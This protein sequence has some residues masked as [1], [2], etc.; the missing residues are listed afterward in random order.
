MLGGRARILGLV[1]A[2]LGLLTP[3]SLVSGEPTRVLRAHRF[4]GRTWIPPRVLEGQ[5]GLE[6]GTP[7]DDE[8]VQ[9]ALERLLAFRFIE[10]AGPPREEAVDGGRGVD[11]IWPIRERKQVR[12]LAIT[13]KPFGRGEAFSTRELSEDL[14]TRTGQPLIALD[15]EA[16]RQAIRTRYLRAGYPLCEVGA[17]VTEPA[18]GAAEVKLTV[19]EGP[20]VW[21]RSIEIAGNREVPESHILDAMVSRR[22]ILFGLVS[23]GLYDSARFTEDVERV[24]DLYRERGFLEALVAEEPPRYTPDFHGVIAGIKIEEGPRYRLAGVSI[25]GNGKGVPAGLLLKQVHTRPGGF[26]D[27]RSLEEDRRR[28]VRWYEEHYDRVPGIDIRREVR[29]DAADSEV[30]VVFQIDESIHLQTGRVNIAGN[31]RTRD[32]VVRGALDVRPGGPLTEIALQRSGLRLV[33]SGYYEPEKLK[34]T[35][36]PG[37]AVRE[38]DVKVEERRTGM[39]EVGGGAGSGSGEIAHFSVTQTNFDLFAIPGPNRP[40][41]DAFSGGGQRLSLVFEPGTVESE[42]RL[43]FE[44]PYLYNSYQAL[45]VQAGGWQ[46]SREAYDETGVGAEVVLKRFWDQEHRFSSSLAW[47]PEDVNIS[48]LSGRAPPD[49]TAVEGHTLISYPSLRFAWNDL[50]LNYWRGPVGLFAEVRGDLAADA[51]GSEAS[52]FRT[53]MRA[54]YFQPV[55]QWINAALGKDVLGDDPRRLHVLRLGGRFGWSEGLEGDDIPFFERFYLGGPQGGAFRRSGAEG[56]RG[57][58]YRGV[59]PEENGV[60]IGGRAYYHLITEYSFPLVIPELRLV[61]IFEAADIEPEFGRLS[62]ARIR[63]AAGGGLRI[64]MRLLGQPLP[65]DFYFVKALAKEREDDDRFFTFNIGFGF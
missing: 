5:I 25:R 15:L 51:T 44:E 29:L 46:F 26:Y 57:F 9:A 24:R 16:D 19:E 38:V 33:E 39:I 59:G 64:R 45:S 62:A 21:L 35:P 42:L 53:V 41:R 60:R 6:P 11:L 47:V 30:D 32:R 65:M 52:F 37:G 8:S 3:A 28:L 49:V 61:G 17:E 10:T 34:V 54:D 14:R 12:K 13:V 27:G 43:S 31:V 56:F 58:D 1:L 2:A 20:K 23:R 7:L 4:E 63:T 36:Q 50:D 48:H 18:P 40:L 22:R 55:S